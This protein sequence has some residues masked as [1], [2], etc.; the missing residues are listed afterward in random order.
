M[1][2]ALLSFAVAGGSFAEP[3]QWPTV[4]TYRVGDTKCSGTLVHPEVIVTAAHCLEDGDT[5]RVRFGE[6]FSPYEIRVDVQRCVVQEAYFETRSPHDD[7]AACVLTEPVDVP[8]VP[9]AMG[10]DAEALVPGAPAAIVGFGLPGAEGEFGRKSWAATV[11]ADEPRPAALLAVGD[12]T[13]NGCLGDSGGPGFLQL[14]D[15][16]WRTFGI[17]VAGPACGDG[18]STFARLDAR[19]AWLEAET[20]FDLTPC[21]DADGTWNPGIS[22]AAIAGNPVTH[23]GTWGDACAQSLVDPVGPCPEGLELPTADA[24]YPADDGHVDPSD[25]PRPPE[26]TGGRCTTGGG[27]PTWWCL[28]V[29]VGGVARR[30]RRERRRNS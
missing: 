5:A 26:T 15:G 14:P 8:I 9:I 29:V 6:D 12:D 25:D 17:L 20:G 11:I 23:G 18:V 1:F 13:V 3:C 4:A 10:C 2:A 7:Y 30:R 28:F 24:G 21:H 19:V 27:A 16:T 22:C